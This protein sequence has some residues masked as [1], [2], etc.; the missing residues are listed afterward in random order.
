VQFEC[1]IPSF[2]THETGLFLVNN[3]YQALKL[4]D[5]EDS[6]RASMKERGISDPSVFMTWLMEEK[7][8]LAQLLT[9]PVEETLEMDYY[10]ARVKLLVCQ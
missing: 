6:L 2:D 1:H 7:E 3:Y 4:L 10:E 5:T 9:V 8:Y